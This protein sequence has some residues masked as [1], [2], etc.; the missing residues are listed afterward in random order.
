MSFFGLTANVGK[1]RFF[2]LFSSWLNVTAIKGCDLILLL[3]WFS[4][5]WFVVLVLECQ[6]HFGSNISFFCAFDGLTLMSFVEYFELLRF[7]GL[8]KLEM[9][10]LDVW[11]LLAGSENLAKVAVIKLV[12]TTNVL[13]KV[14]IELLK[15]VH[16]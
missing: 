5:K 13:C 3:R 1:W 10:F 4:V 8:A 12:W 2:A 16:P 11:K 14:L 9:A 7:A 15:L 6:T